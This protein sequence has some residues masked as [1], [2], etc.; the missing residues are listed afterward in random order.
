MC[1][2]SVCICHIFSMD[3][4][5]PINLYLSAYFKRLGNIF[6]NI[7]NNYINFNYVNS[8]LSSRSFAFYTV[9]ERLPI[10]LTKII[11]HLVRDKEKIVKIFG[12]VLHYLF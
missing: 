8:F 7:S 4:K 3:S 12:E 5:T 1:D 9:K 6:S 10:I 11:D 2:Q